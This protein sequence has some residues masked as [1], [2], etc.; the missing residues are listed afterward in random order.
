MEG[1]R[2]MRPSRRRGGILALLL[3]STALVG[4]TPALA[5]DT[6]WD[7]STNS[8]WF[9]DSNWDTNAE[10]LAGDN[11]FITNV[12]PTPIVG[13]PG[14]VANDVTVG[15]GVTSGLFVLGTGV[16]T[17]NGKLTIGTNGGTGTVTVQNGGDLVLT[18]GDTVLGS[19]NNATGNLTVTGPGS[20]FQ[21]VQSF[22]IGHAGTGNFTL[23][24]GATASTSAIGL[25]TNPGGVGT[26]LVTGAGTQLTAG[27]ITVGH[28]GDG[29]FTLAGGA[30]AVINTILT[31][32]S[33]A[34]SNGILNLTGG[35]TMCVGG[36]CGGNVFIAT[37]AGSTGIINI[38]NGSA[39]DQL[40]AGTFQFG[41]GTGTL[42]FNHTSTNYF[43]YAT[44]SGAGT[45]N[46]I[47]GVTRLTADSSGFTGTTNITGGTLRVNGALGST[48]NVFGGTLR[49]SGTLTG[50]LS[51]ASGGT[52]APGNSIGTLNVANIT[53][54]AGSTYTVELN[55]GG[56]LAGTN[57]DRILA[58]GAATI[59]GG[60]VHVT[61]F[62]TGD[63]GSTYT[64]GTYTIL[65]AAGGVTGT[66]DT[67]TDDYAF[68]NFALGYDANNVLL[69][70]SLAATSFCLTG[71]SANQCAAGEGSFSLGAGNS[72]FDAVLALSNAE[73]PGAL[74]QLSGEI[75]ASL[76]T[77]LIEDSRFVRETANDRIRNAF[78][79]VG[80]NA[81][82]ISAY[83]MTYGGTSGDALP[84]AVDGAAFW[85]RGHGAWGEWDGNGNAAA[86]DRS[87]GGFLVGADALA[88]DDIRLGLLGGFSR[89][90]LDIAGR[91][92]SGTVESYSLGAYGGGVWGGF[93]LRG[94]AAV[95]WHDVRTNRG[96]AFT[97]FADSLTADYDAR[98][99]QVF[100]EAAY[101][102]EYGQVRL[103]PFGN[104]AYVNVATEGFAETGGA[105]ALTVAAG[106]DDASFATLGLRAEGVLP[107]GLMEACWHG[108]LGYRR[109][110]S[111][112]SD[113]SLAF[114]SGGSAFAIEGVPVARD[115]LALDLGIDLK[116]SPNASVGISGSGQFGSGVS[117][118]SLKAEFTI[119][120]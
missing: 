42:N 95:A 115:A 30:S 5:T 67:L 4:V 66:F 6:T 82:Q 2:G 112:N 63:D 104:L 103:E 60:T 37:Q 105:A 109:A 29:T 89:T 14:A 70:S 50:A 91:R 1:G 108:S 54:A 47:A 11:V 18:S 64:P 62:P 75:H 41:A 86:F 110:F 73:A 25:G 8:N 101:G 118:Q 40:N 65:T 9:D 27:S 16:L 72:I 96:V 80:A 51:V 15:D 36:G 69:T 71:M 38:G 106:T 113:A 31:V 55:D 46:Q 3:T 99:L 43:V 32:G 10:P 34:G 12:G 45:I 78:S 52:I 83:G 93:S 120:F 76:T 44:I 7:G 74:D 59:N 13:G 19:T 22:Y 102:F 79:D 81:S 117:D 90:D 68:L 56:F 20:Y 58:T 26:A 35:S 17:S 84:S 85:G 48:V 111:G 57:N 21:T 53:M 92:S 28:L 77:A 33:E 97:G 39:A 116:L 94:G 88:K 114:A 98:S 24:D 49:G 107:A 61:S 100:A 23:A 119:N 87:I